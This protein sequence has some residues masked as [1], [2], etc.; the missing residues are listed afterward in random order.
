[1]KEEKEKFTTGLKFKSHEDMEKFL[2]LYYQKGRKETL[3]EVK[4]EIEKFEKKM[5]D[6]NLQKEWNKLK[7][8][9]EMK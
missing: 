6:G 7:K 3:Q 1:M 4:N 5:Y 8:N 9:L 2:D